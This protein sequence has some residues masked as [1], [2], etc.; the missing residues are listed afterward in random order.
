[1]RFVRQRLSGATLGS[2]AHSQGIDA[3]TIAALKPDYRRAPARAIENQALVDLG[4]DLFFDPAISASGTTA[5]VGCHLPQLG[6]AVTEAQLQAWILCRNL[7]PLA[8]NKR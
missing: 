8:K 5:C 3:A 1:L 6:W 2:V 7:D 4:R